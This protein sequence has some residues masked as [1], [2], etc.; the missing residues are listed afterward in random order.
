MDVSTKRSTVVANNVPVAPGCSPTRWWRSIA[1]P[2]FHSMALGAMKAAVEKVEM[3]G[4]PSWR[5]AVAGDAAAAVGTAILFDRQKAAP[6]KLDLAMTA[7]VVCACEGD[8]ASCLMIAY[9][10]K[11]LPKAGRRE[12]RLSTSWTVRAMRPFLAKVE[13]GV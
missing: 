5:D 11:R 2:N 3:L 6:G 12:K 1:A 8:A 9:M 4:E 10:L 13:A 7:L